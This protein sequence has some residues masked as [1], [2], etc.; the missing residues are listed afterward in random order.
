L[1]N[2]EISPHYESWG[3]L[4]LILVYT[5]FDFSSI[6]CLFGFRLKKRFS[7]IEIN[8]KMNLKI[9]ILGA[10]FFNND[11]MKSSVSIKDQVEMRKKRLIR[12]W[13]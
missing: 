11:I 13:L 4:A 8:K 1:Y 7:R 3:E 5:G 12:R 6:K 2:K 10:V 9:Q